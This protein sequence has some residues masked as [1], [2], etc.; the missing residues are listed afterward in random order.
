MHITKDQ[1]IYRNLTIQQ[2]HLFLQPV[3]L[4][5]S[6]GQSNWS[7]YIIYDDHDKILAAW[8]FTHQHKLGIHRLNPAPYSAYNDIIIFDKKAETAILQQ[9]MKTIPYLSLIKINQLQP[10]TTPSWGQQIIKRRQSIV[11]RPNLDDYMEAIQPR[12]RSLIRKALNTYTITATSNP[13]ELLSGMKESFDRQYI[14]LLQST[15]LQRWFDIFDN[16]IGFIIK[17]VDNRILGS[18]IAIE[19]Q[20]ILYAVAGGKNYSKNQPGIME[21]LYWHL[22]QQGHQRQCDID[23]CGSS[24]PG[25]ADFNRRM[26]GSESTYFQHLIT[27]PHFLLPLLKLWK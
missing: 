16:I 1:K 5:A 11:Y 17:D 20:H 7:A 18:M 10:L 12:K 24:L 6:L 23:L 22:I 3:W 2:K 14:P 25:V 9:L 15:T 27:R 26:G 21:G 8:P 4:D 13:R 19:H